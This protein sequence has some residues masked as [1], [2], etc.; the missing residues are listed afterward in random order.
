[1]SVRPSIHLFVGPTLIP[2]RTV[3]F[4]Y[5]AISRPELAL[6]IFF[7]GCILRRSEN[8]RSHFFKFYQADYDRTLL[9]ALLGGFIDLPGHS[10]G[11]RNFI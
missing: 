3:D 9:W 7:E 8:S 10:F 2:L 11:C 1:M 5:Q 4:L 6:V